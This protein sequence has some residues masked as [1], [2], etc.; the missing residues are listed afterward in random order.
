MK[1]KTLI[2]F[3]I[4]NLGLASHILAQEKSPTQIGMASFYADKFEGKTTSNGEIYYHIKKTAA[5]RTLPFGT[6]VKVTNLK[7]NKFIVVRINDRGP[8]TDNRIIDL[9][10]S[11]A[12]K[13]DFVK[14]GIAKVKVEVIAN[15]SN[16]PDKKPI[17][18]IISGSTYYKLDSKL[19]KPKGKGIQI[20][21]YSDDE[22]IIKQIA[23][24]KL[25]TKQNIYIEIAKVKD[26]KVYRVIVG[27]LVDLEEL[28]KLKKSLKK[29][30]PDCF[31]IEYK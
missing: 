20:G 31:I 29:K 17:K 3:L 5:H 2:A 9:S 22:S 18:Q 12:Q 25:D 8:F 6:I 23:N 7:N 24:L 14:E 10:K 21:S 30:F 4:V 16:L 1:I 19:E 15:T 28:T 27:N 13:L 11:S 26:Q